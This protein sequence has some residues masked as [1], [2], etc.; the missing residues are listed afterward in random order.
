M[1]IL[2]RFVIKDLSLNKKRTIVTIIGIILS[3]AL[4][5]AVAGMVTSF[6]KTLL[7]YEKEANGNYHVSIYDV[8]PEDVQKIKKNEEIE[9]FYNF[10]KYKGYSK[11]E[12]SKNEYKPYICLLGYNKESLE[13]LK[14][15]EGRLPQNDNE[16]VIPYHILTNGK[17]D[18]KI[19][20]K[21]SL[22]VSDRV[23]EG[24][25]LSQNNPY[26]EEIE[27]NLEF[28]YSKEYEIVGIVSRPNQQI[29]PHTA[30]GYSVITL[31]NDF[32]KTSSENITLS[33][34]YKDSKNYKEKT[35]KIINSTDDYKVE[36]NTNL[37]RFEGS[38]LSDSTMSMLYSVAG[39]V[40]VIIIISSVF[41]IKNS[42]SISITEKIRQYGILSSIGATSKQIKKNVLFEGFV[43]GIIAI[44]IGILSGIFAV[45]I[46][47]HLINYI[48]AEALDGI[49]FIYSVPVMPILIS[50]LF[51]SVTIY[52]STIFSARKASK[53]SPIEAIRSNTEIKISSKKVKSS[54]IIKKLF[55]VGGDISYK[56][57]KRN[58][59]KYRSTVVSLVISV[60]IFISLSSFLDFGFKMA[61]EYYKEMDY[62]LVLYSGRYQ[63]ADNDK[64]ITTFEDIAKLN[65]VMNYSIVKTK[66]ILISNSYLS[67][68]GKLY[69]GAEDGDSNQFEIIIAIGDSE[70]KKF[71]EE[72]G[73]KV[74]DYED[75]GILVNNTT[76]F[77]NN[78]KKN[79]DMYNIKAGDSINLNKIG[80]EVGDDDEVLAGDSFG[81]KIAKVTDKRPMGMS[82]G[83]G[84][85]VSDKMMEE[86]KEY[87]VSNMYIMSDDSGK[88]SD[89]IKSLI[90]SDEKY[91]KSTNIYD[92]EEAR[93]SENAMVLV[94]S[95]FLYGF[96]TVI[97]LIAV[98]NI[99]NTI[100]TTMNL[101]QKEFAMLK[102]I[103]M[104]KSEFNRMIKLESIFYGS[105]S[106]IIGIP[107]GC[108]G[109]YF[110]YKAFSE[111]MDMSYK[112][113]ITSIIISIIF[114][115][116]I[117]GL[118][119]KYSLDKINKQ[120]IIET[121][122]K[123]NI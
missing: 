78:K 33:F 75:K 19:G 39:V 36:Y 59:R 17:L 25:K 119:M 9:S 24:D 30:P 103:G 45:F 16:V 47:I 120:N 71:V 29:E 110:V 26:D 38:A 63:E 122:R 90:D 77:Y 70:Y 1:S 93:R 40:I 62:N 52:L 65:N 84:I 28:R 42:F 72:I 51:A 58:K 74:E 82:D 95:I 112:L 53:I 49:T 79:G 13:T 27:E 99:F 66:Q 3:T 5:C 11:L 55:K 106:L 8:T 69:Y 67:D 88:L 18:Y 109:S 98:T 121:I 64:V 48:L 23:L 107:L 102:S 6:Y 50:V 94:V 7:E 80:E 41:V 113:P 54:K 118:I 81:I 2:N 4:I 89:D 20:D 68:L 34:R 76:F 56:N 108:I 60:T 104:T 15:S 87:K 116:L 35:E 91:N 22:D 44:P 85:V 111:G 10:Y 117:V 105:K 14:L 61:N 123:E 37:L 43:L 114:V 97:T 21:I 46:L 86:I 100:T 115:F 57:L 73:G 92:Y 83:T 101:R 12:D 31:D 32:G 96:I